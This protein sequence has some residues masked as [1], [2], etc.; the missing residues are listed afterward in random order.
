VLTLAIM[1]GSLANATSGDEIT[2]RWFFN[3]CTYESDI[4]KFTEV[5][6]G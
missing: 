4:Q 5:V 2:S 6:D 1:L 3:V